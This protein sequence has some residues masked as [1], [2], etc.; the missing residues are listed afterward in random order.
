MLLLNVFVPFL[1]VHLGDVGMGS[2][3]KLQVEGERNRLQTI[4]PMTLRT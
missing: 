1:H 3:P 4:S 2:P